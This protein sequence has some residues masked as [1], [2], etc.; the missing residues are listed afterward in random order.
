MFPQILLHI[1]WRW[2]SIMKFDPRTSRGFVPGKLQYQESYF[3]LPTHI[4][5]ETCFFKQI[6]RQGAHYIRDV[7]HFGISGQFWAMNQCFGTIYSTHN[8]QKLEPKHATRRLKMR[9][10]GS[11]VVPKSSQY[12]VGWIFLRHSHFILYFITLP[13]NQ[14][15]TRKRMVLGKHSFSAFFFGWFLNPMNHLD[16]SQKVLLRVGDRPKTCFFL[17]PNFK[18]LA[19]SD[20]HLGDR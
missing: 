18:G 11:K 4:F 15:S 12:S 1:M 9:A 7:P 2:R 5:K 10:Y 3:I 16:T 19:S 17:W 20:L 13:D 6:F 8:N 14:L